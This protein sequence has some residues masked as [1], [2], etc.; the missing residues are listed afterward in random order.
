MPKTFRVLS[1]VRDYMLF[2][3]SPQ[4]SCKTS[5]FITGFLKSLVIMISLR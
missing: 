5:K 4:I 2:M 1:Y 3:M